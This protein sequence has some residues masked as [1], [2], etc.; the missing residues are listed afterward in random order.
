MT[1]SQ[2]WI[3]CNSD[4]KIEQLQGQLKAT[5]KLN[6]TAISRIQDA[7]NRQSKLLEESKSFLDIN[8]IARIKSILENLT[9]EGSVQNLY[10]Q[11]PT[12]INLTQGVNKQISNLLTQMNDLSDRYRSLDTPFGGAIPVGF[13]EMLAVFPLALS[14]VFCYVAMT[15]RDTIRLRRVLSAQGIAENIRNYISNSPLWIDPKPSPGSG[16]ILHSIIAWT[17]LAIP[18]LLFIGSIIIISFILFW[19]PIGGDKFPVFVAA[20]EFNKL[21]YSTFYV[22]GGIL[23]GFSYSLIIKEVRK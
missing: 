12:V 10:G 1:R 20:A 9:S 14:I 2:A 21:S 8:K 5:I 13:N 6:D 18:F 15:L 3:I 22:I 19:M 16:K 17:V 4:I 23:F 7:I 11:Q